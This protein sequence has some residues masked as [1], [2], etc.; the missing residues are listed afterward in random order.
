[1]VDYDERWRRRFEAAQKHLALKERALAYKG[2]QC[3]IC[4]YDGCPAALHFHYADSADREFFISS[5]TRWVDV[6][7][8]LDR[9]TL[10]CANCRAEVRAAWHPGHLVLE[11]QERY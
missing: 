8:A 11:D 1:M 9:T 4:G 3:V 5:A 2:G 10:L 6:Q 7:A